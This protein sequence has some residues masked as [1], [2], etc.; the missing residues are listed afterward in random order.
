MPTN[1]IL[2]TPKGELQWAKVLGEPRGFDGD[3]EKREWSVTLLL[4]DTDPAC[5]ELM[6]TIREKYVEEHGKKKPHQH[7]VPFKPHVDKD[8]NAT[9]KMQFTFKRREFT[10]R[11][12][13]KGPPIVVDSTGVNQWPSDKLIG[14][15]S[16]GRIKFH[17][18]PWGLGKPN[19]GVGM[20]LRGLQVLDLVEYE[21]QEDMAF[22]AEESGYV[23]D[24]GESFGTPCSIEPPAGSFQSKVSAAVAE[25]ATDEEMPF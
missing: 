6:K 9:G 4:E 8:G 17:I 15:G 7:G 19:P 24:Q 1:Q 13:A 20:E 18:Y 14:N 23:L 3:T 5:E 25:L 2:F 22:K 10:T 12:D 11:G 21:T 16:I